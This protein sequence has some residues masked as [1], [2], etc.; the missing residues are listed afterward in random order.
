MLTCP[1]AG[2]TWP[3][4]PVAVACVQMLLTVGSGMA[5]RQCV[6]ADDIALQVTKYLTL[7]MFNVAVPAVVLLVLGFT[8]AA[9]WAVVQFVVAWFL[10]RAAALLVIVLLVLSLRGLRMRRGAAAGCGL[11]EVVVH[12]LAL[13]WISTII[14]GGPVVA[15]ITCSESKGHIYGTLAGVTS[16]VF[17]LPLLLFLLEVS[18]Q[19]G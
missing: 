11:G 3:Y 14:V 2:T 13:A 4:L 12:W 8:A 17:Q 19:A 5:F 15:A 10:L 9:D 1:F 6:I 18:A 7:Y 16:Y